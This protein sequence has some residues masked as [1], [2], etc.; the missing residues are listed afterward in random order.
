MKGRIRLAPVDGE[1]VLPP[2]WHL[3]HLSLVLLMLLRR[4]LRLSIAPSLHSRRLMGI[5]AACR[6]QGCL[7]IIP[8]ALF[9]SLLS[10]EIQSAQVASLWL[11]WLQWLGKERVIFTQSIVYHDIGALG[12][13]SFAVLAC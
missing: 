13:R 12:S 3:A 2:K 7:V 6:Q 4:N 1:E 10:I 11:V 8:F 9:Y 5:L